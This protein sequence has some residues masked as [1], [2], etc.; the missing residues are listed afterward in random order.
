MIRS[1]PRTSRRFRRC[2]RCTAGIMPGERYLSLVASPDHGDLGNQQWWR[3]TECAECAA[4][5]GRPIT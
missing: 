2:D 3:G 5:C 1:T 4:L